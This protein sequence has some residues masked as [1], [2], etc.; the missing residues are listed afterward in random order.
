MEPRSTPS[1]SNAPVLPSVGNRRA[2]MK[3][4]RDAVLGMIIVY[5][6]DPA[7]DDH[8]TRTLVFETQG[9]RVRLDSFPDD[10]RRLGDKELIALLTRAKT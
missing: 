7:R 3:M 2:T 9:T 6:L 4:I 5:E 8:A 10:W 1:E